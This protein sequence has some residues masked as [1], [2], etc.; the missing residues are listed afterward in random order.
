VSGVGPSAHAI[1]AV[2]MP[3]RIARKLEELGPCPLA[4][5]E[6]CRWQ[7]QGYFWARRWGSARCASGLS[8]GPPVD[9]CRP[10]W[11]L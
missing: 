11:Y 8:Y 5:V 7:K 10:H 4:R 6:K 3:A 2:V 1:C 9:R